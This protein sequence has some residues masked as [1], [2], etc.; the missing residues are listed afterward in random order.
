VWTA[1][2]GLTLRAALLR[3]PTLG[4]QSY[5]FDE[6]ATLKVVDGSFRHAL[7]KITVSESTPPLYYVLAWLWRHVFGLHEFGFRLLP[8]L[9]G[10]LLVPAV[11][12]L[13]RELASARVGL[14]AAALVA[15]SPYLVFYSQEA[16]AYSLFALLSVLGLL[17]CVRAIRQPTDAAF[18]LWA[19]V[20]IVAV[21]THYFAL[22]P[23]AG[24]VVAF[25]VY[26]APRRRTALWWAAVAVPTI[27][28]L[29]L[30]RH[31]ANIGHVGWIGASSLTQ[32]LRVTVETFALGATFKGSLSHSVLVACAFLA[33]VIGAAII[34][35]SVLIVRRSDA[36]ERWSVGLVGVVTVIT[37][38][39][40]LIGALGPGDYFIH[41]NVISALPQCAVILSLGLGSK[42]AGRLG[43]WATVCITA[44]G[45]ALTVMSFAVPAMRRPDVRQASDEPGTPMR[46]RVLT[47]VPRWEL[48][49]EHYQ[50]NVHPLP[51]GGRT[52]DEI[53]VFTLSKELPPGTVP[54][55][56]RVAGMTRGNTFN[57]FRFRSATGVLI[58]PDDVAPH[59]F[60]ESGLQPIADYQPAAGSR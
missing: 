58:R 18:A 56:F 3:L 30:A 48:V 33:L 12:A 7:H 34:V 40:P 8:A 9:A 26:G 14:A 39:I 44:A 13:G 25:V 38:A 47:F 37:L 54:A 6:A 16:R 55:G 15:T 50:H 19:V 17:C 27:P 5:E 57:L 21:A 4:L 51:E 23:L 2:A 59:T 36:A 53:D 42:R 22:F 31:Q 43:V 41:K 60:S 29:V 45:V 11:F 20:S 24:Q 52:V 32:R 10:V 49:L 1:L 46:A 28:L 35:A